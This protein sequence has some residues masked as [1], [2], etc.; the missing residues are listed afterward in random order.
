MCMKK[1]KV[2]QKSAAQV[3]LD[4]ELAAERAQRKA[5]IRLELRRDKSSRTE[6][7]IARATGRYGMRS[8]IS[9]SRGG[10]GFALPF[11]STLATPETA[12]GGNADPV[13]IPASAMQGAPPVRTR[14]ATYDKP[15][16]KNARGFP[17]NFA[18]LIRL[19]F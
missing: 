1:P 6:E 12:A 8:L 4:K 13:A 2:P 10:Q 15:L 11:T 9:G 17:G 5:E 14:R 3:A 19:P 18:S 7:A 16:P